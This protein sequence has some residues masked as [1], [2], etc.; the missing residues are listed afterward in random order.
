MVYVLWTLDFP[1]TR[2]SALIFS[3][4]W[5]EGLIII[6]RPNH[7][8][9]P[10]LVLQARNLPYTG[11]FPPPWLLLISYIISQRCWGGRCEKVLSQDKRFVIFSSRDGE[12]G[13]QWRM[14]RAVWIS[15]V[16]GH[17]DQGLTGFFYDQVPVLFQHLRSNKRREQR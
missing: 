6:I 14:W 7:P 13:T 10:S 16:S 11:F 1:L 2:L 9:Q 17:A 12:A 15:G 4:Q 3:D 8:T 5:H